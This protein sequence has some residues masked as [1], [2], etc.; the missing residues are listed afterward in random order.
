MPTGVVVASLVFAATSAS[1]PSPNK[2]F[3]RGVAARAS[4]GLA[5]CPPST[6]TMS[7]S[8][9]AL[10]WAARR[11]FT[12]ARSL[13]GSGPQP[14]TTVDQR[15]RDRYV[16][17]PSAPQLIQQVRT[18]TVHG[19]M[20]PFGGRGQRDRTRPLSQGRRIKRR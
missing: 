19:S 10:A 2:I 9:T 18:V 17:M 11:T 6:E 8:A 5:R 16:E 14:T 4:G 12:G 1:G 15:R 20:D 7:T 3:G 13:I